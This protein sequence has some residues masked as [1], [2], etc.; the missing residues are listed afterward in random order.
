MP[1]GPTTP[2]S[3]D[4]GEYLSLFVARPA[5][6]AQIMWWHISDLSLQNHLHLF[7]SRKFSLLDRDID[8]QSYAADGIYWMLTS[9]NAEFYTSCT[10]TAD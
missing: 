4:I 1:I 6:T 3:I 10:E 8:N 5:K 7:L 9:L 2:V